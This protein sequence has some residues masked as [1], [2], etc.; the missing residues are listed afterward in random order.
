MRR[1]IFGFSLVMLAIG[2]SNKVKAQDV[3]DGIYQP[4]HTLE[5]RVIPYAP[6]READVMWLRRVWRRIDLREKNESPHLLP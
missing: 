4:E 3:L 1:L 6:L 5:R 2:F